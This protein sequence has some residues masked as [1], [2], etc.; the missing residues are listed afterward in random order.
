MSKVKVVLDYNAMNRLRKTPEF[1]AL[2]QDKANEIAGRCGQGYATDHK[3]MTTRVIASVYTAM[4]SAMV[5]NS[6]NN[7]LLREM[8]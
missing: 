5:D 8:H 6:Q 2:V 1:T 4:N 7:T 3:Y